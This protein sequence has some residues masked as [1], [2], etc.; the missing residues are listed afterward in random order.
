MVAVIWVVLFLLA[1]VWFSW[2]RR[3]PIYRAHRRIGVVSGQSGVGGVPGQSGV[4]NTPTWYGD[5]HVPPLLPEL[6]P[7]V[8]Q[9]T[10][11]VRRWRIG[12]NRRPSAATALLAERRGRG[13]VK[14]LLSERSMRRGAAKQLA[15][16]KRLRVAQDPNTRRELKPEGVTAD[17]I[18]ARSV[19]RYL[20]RFFTPSEYPHGRVAGRLACVYFALTVLVIISAVL[21]GNGDGAFTVDLAFVATLPLSLGLLVGQDDSPWMLA[22]LAVCALVNAFVFWVVFRGDPA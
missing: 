14:V 21:E 4:G 5:R 2:F 3:T 15:G 9:A 12:R 8:D 22:A 20:R 10:P 19:G 16:A 7:D 11:R 17:R 18:R 6:R 1:V 13:S